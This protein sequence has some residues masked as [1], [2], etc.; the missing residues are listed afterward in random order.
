MNPEVLA[1]PVETN[2]IPLWVKLLYSGFMLV[3]V[4]FYWK[5]Y[6]PTNFLYFC[7]VALFMALAAVWLER[8]IWASLPAVG[9]LVPQSIWMVDFLAGLA[10]WELTGMTAYMFDSGIPVFA[11]LLSLFHFWLPLLLIWLLWRL[12]YDP[13]A[14]WGWIIIAWLL[15]AISYFLLPMP[16]APTAQPNLPVNVNYVFGPSSDQAQTWMHPSAYFGL[17]MVL[18]PLVVYWPTHLVLR[19]IFAAAD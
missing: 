14:G 1:T 17:M 6:G 3:L 5:A 16:P 7:D 11:R 9:L 13:R 15:L 8:S 4:P 2:T 19:K 12:G 10:G 18:L